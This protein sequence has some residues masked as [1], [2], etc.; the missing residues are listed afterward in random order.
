MRRAGSF[1]CQYRTLS[2]LPHWQGGGDTSDRKIYALA[3]DHAGGVWIATDEGLDHLDLHSNQIAQLKSGGETAPRNFSVMQDR[4]G[5]LWLGNEKGLFVRH[6]GSTAFVR[7]QR[8]AGVAS[9][10]LN[11]QIWPCARMMPDEC[12]LAL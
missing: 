11:N 1:R 3:D 9:T 6:A 2:H 7:P 8:S 12:G 10:V 4:A 5:N